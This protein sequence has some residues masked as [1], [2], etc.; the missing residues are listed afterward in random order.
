MQVS[1][2]FPDPILPVLN[3]IHDEADDEGQAGDE[4]EDVQYRFRRNNLGAM[5]RLSEFSSKRSLA[6]S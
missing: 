1:S 3:V 5:S 4:D 6:F 2:L